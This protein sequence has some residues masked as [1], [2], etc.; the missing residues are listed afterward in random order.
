MHLFLRCHH[1]RVRCSFS[2][3]GIELIQYQQRRRREFILPSLPS[4]CTC[5]PYRVKAVAVD[6]VLVHPNT[7]GDTVWWCTGSHELNAECQLLA[8]CQPQP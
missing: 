8:E 3:R 4:A 6:T 7:T 1:L 5:I 2:L